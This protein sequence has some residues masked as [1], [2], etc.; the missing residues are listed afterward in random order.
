M[1]NKDYYKTLGVN[2]NASADEIK[3]AYKKLVFKYHP[4]KNP[5]DK[6][7]EEMFKDV[8]EAYAVL[9]DKDK[10]AQYD[11]F[12]SAGFHKR[13]SQEDIFRG[14][15]FS[16]IFGEMG[17]NPEDI[18]SFFKTGRS[19]GGFRRTS[20]AG[21]GG[22][23]RVED[24]FGGGGFN[25]QSRPQTGQDL[26][27]ELSIDFM[28]AAK[29]CEKT[30]EYMYGGKKKSLKVKIPPGIET[31]QKLRLQGKGGDAGQLNKPGDLF[32]KVKVQPDAVFKREGSDIIVEKEIKLSEA[33]LGTTVEVPTLNGT[34]KMKIPA[35]VQNNTRM[36]LKGEGFP[37]FGK[38]GF[39]DEYVRIIV[40]TPKNITN[41]QKKIF[42]SL[43][44]QGL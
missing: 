29:G 24:I 39:G 15:N 12:G 7:A 5:G 2:K 30:I 35:G 11:R 36:R 8:S 26:M 16:D 3:K 37:L 21:G 17:F 25:Q 1:S 22:G 43:A 40:K 38:T 32:I 28:E 13:Y 10:R 6:K 9:S 44:E 18:F 14:S 4:D 27:L 41:E 19:G 31:G 33:V 20:T 23:F 42:R 34:K